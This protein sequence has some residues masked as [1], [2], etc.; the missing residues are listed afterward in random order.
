M[1]A[2]RQSLLA[3][4]ADRP[5]ADLI[6]ALDRT[7]GELQGRV[8]ALEGTPAAQPLDEGFPDGPDRLALMLNGKVAAALVAADYGSV[9]AV[10]SASDA[11]LLAAPG[12][13]AK[14]LKFIRSK[15]GG[16]GL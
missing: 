15:V 13:D 7:L 2:D 1:T 4:V 5:A 12:I 6:A 3:A 9:A 8:A 14:S 11:D 16:A 10:R